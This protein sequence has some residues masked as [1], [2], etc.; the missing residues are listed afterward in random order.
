MSKNRARR[1]ELGDQIQ[2]MA[3]RRPREAWDRADEARWLALN[4][5]FDELCLRGRSPPRPPSGRRNR[6]GH[7]LLSHR[8]RRGAGAARPCRTGDHH[9]DSGG[10]GMMWGPWMGGRENRRGGALRLRMVWAP[11]FFHHRGARSGRGGN[12]ERP[13]VS[14]FFALPG[15]A[16]LGSLGV[17]RGG[18]QT[19]QVVRAELTCRQ[20]PKACPLGSLSIRR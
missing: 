12:Y 9:R 19:C 14:C 2:E 17:C 7:H 10:A 11:P 1:V 8:P 6:G 18:G 15:P 3:Q 5:E 4:N 13:L 20:P 16:I